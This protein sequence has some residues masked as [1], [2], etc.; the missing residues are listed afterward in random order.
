MEFEEE[1]AGVF[2]LPLYSAR[3]CKSIL[4]HAKSP[5][6]W[7]K[8]QSRAQKRGGYNSVV[9]PEIRS[10][11]VFCPAHEPKVF[12]N[13]D[14][15]MRKVINPLIRRTWHVDFLRPS[16]T[17]IVRYAPG[18]HFVAHS[19]AGLDMQHRYFT[20]LCYLNE[21]F[22][23]GATGFPELNYSV[24]PK[25]GKAIVFPARYLHGGKPIINGYKYLFISFLIGPVP[26]R[27]I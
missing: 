7:K 21:D 11:S 3:S 4:D 16:E 20:V 2:A 8:A 25:C 24:V 17:H 27:W 5:R 15:K 1:V 22:E 9:K 18:D 14:D 6:G 26:I 23:G 19:D 10:A 12:Q 13:F